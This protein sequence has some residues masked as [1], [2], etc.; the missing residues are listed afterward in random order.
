MPLQTAMPR[1]RNDELLEPLLDDPPDDDEPEDDELE[2][3]L[4]EDE[5]DEGDELELDELDELDDVD[6][7]D[8]LD[9]LPDDED[10]ALLLEDNSELD[11][12]VGAVGLSA[13][14]GSSPSAVRLAPPER[15]SRNS[16]RSLSLVCIRLRRQSTD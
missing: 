7:P 6:E 5:L 9:E 3:R 14:P 2:D 8:E 16:R 4:D 1:A 12:L 15:R 13:H 10:P 11:E